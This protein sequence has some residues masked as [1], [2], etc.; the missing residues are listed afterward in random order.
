LEVKKHLFSYAYQH[1]TVSSVRTVR[2]SLKDESL[3][4]KGKRGKVKGEGKKEREKKERKSPL[5]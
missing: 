3:K 5:P 4:A 2:F 1:I